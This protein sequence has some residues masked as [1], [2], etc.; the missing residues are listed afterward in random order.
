[1]LNFVKNISIFDVN[2]D[3]LV[4]PVNCVGIMD[5]GLALEFKKRYPGMYR[6]Y[7]WGCDVGAVSLG[8]YYDLNADQNETILLIPTKNNSED[9][10][11]IK[12]VKESFKK[13]IRDIDFCK[14]QTFSIAISDLD[15]DFTGLDW[16]NDV[17]PVIIELFGKYS[18]SKRVNITILE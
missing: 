5:K 13:L 8:Y 6:E 4:C 10:S 9:E 3:A 15:W 1:M 7:K 2:A 11:H 14:H 12:D 17:K 18:D 16:N